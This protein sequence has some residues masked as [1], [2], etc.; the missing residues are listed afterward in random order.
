MKT[1][2]IQIKRN[3]KQQKKGTNNWDTKKKKQTRK[4]NT[5][6]ASYHIWWRPCGFA[7]NHLLSLILFSSL[8]CL[9]GCHLTLEVCA[10]IHNKHIYIQIFMYRST[11]TFKHNQFHINT[12]YIY[13]LACT[14]IVSGLFSFFFL[15]HEHKITNQ[16][17]DWLTPFNIVVVIQNA[18]C[19][20][21][22]HTK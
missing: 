15:F 9:Y 5:V 17:I 6:S 13:A 12:K 21:L 2:R 18:M 3:K 1:I 4:Q 22:F 10:H 19:F 11:L 7:M 16:K 20:F 8:I 14:S